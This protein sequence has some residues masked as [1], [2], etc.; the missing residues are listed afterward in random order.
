MDILKELDLET[1]AIKMAE[2][3]SRETKKNYNEDLKNKIYHLLK[4]E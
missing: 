2:L 3:Y 1:V 4:E